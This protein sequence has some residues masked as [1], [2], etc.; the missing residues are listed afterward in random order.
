MNNKVKY[1]QLFGTA[2][3]FKTKSNTTE[4][5]IKAFTKIV[6]VLDLKS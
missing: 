5:R 1:C 3:P 6:H 4:G 2:R